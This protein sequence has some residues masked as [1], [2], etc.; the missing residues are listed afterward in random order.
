LCE[1]NK[2]MDEV[3]DLHLKINH[4][5]REVDEKCRLITDQA[6]KLQDLTKESAKTLKER[7]SYQ[8]QA[9]QFFGHLM[10]IRNQLEGSSDIFDDL[11]AA[12]KSKHEV[13]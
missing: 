2:I 7:N 12:Y 9:S 4:A 8:R 6:E 5:R 13:Q 11:M 1:N 3:S 10:E